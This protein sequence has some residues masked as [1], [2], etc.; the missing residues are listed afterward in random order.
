M[1]P[2]LE[3]SVHMA[4]NECNKERNHCQGVTY[5]TKGPCSVR[6]NAYF[7]IIQCQD[8]GQDGASNPR[9]TQASRG[10]E[11][12]QV[13]TIPEQRDQSLFIVPWRCSRGVNAHVTPR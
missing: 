3:M 5:L 6:S 9:L 12:L 2:R 10:S 1:K 4:P 7:R 11:T 13:I 8:K